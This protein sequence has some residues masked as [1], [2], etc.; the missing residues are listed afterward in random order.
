MLC[1][2]RSYALYVKELYSVTSGAMLCVC[3]SY[4]FGLWEQCFWRLRAL[5]L[6]VESNVFV[7]LSCMPSLPPFE[8]KT[9]VNYVPTHVK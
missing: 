4:A 1:K 3:K 6:G 9:C 5:L 8:L 7:R 2:L